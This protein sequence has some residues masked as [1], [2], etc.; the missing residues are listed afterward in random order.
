MYCSPVKCI[1]LKTYNLRFIGGN[2]FCLYCGMRCSADREELTKKN[3]II[4]Q[5]SRLNFKV[6]KIKAFYN[7]RVLP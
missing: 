1:A 4:L 2:P 3:A 7:G 5:F 6:N